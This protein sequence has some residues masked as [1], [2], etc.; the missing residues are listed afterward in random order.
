[1]LY[2]E[3]DDHS[4]SRI[5]SDGATETNK[6]RPIG[7]IAMEAIRAGMTNKEALAKVRAERLDAGTTI[8][9]INW[10]R[11]KLR[12]DGEDVPTARELRKSREATKA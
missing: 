2:D 5:H 7:V 3:D 10:Y 11:N 12:K 1:M 9:C 4:A 6:P 8:A